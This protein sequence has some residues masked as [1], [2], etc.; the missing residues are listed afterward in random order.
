[1]KIKTLAT[2]CVVLFL[3]ACH[4]NP[5]KSSQTSPLSETESLTT[6][7]AIART[8]FEQVINQRNPD[9]LDSAYAVDYI[10]HG[11]E[12]I[13]MRGLDAARGFASKLLAASNDRQATVEQQVAEGDLV[14]T[15]FT[16]SG[17]HTGEFNGIQPTNNIWTTKGIVISRIE[18]GKIAEDWEIISVSGL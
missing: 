18:N 17:H 14:V 5:D 10:H 13:D 16:S 2:Y 7:K 1:M 15:R 8:W 4:T 11:P 6:N 9:A 12:G 3:M